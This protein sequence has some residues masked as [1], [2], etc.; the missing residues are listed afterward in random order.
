MAFKK[1]LVNLRQEKSYEIDSKIQYNKTFH[2]VFIFVKYYAS[3]CH[4]TLV[5]HLRVRLE[6]YP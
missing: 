5:K 3:V 2:S 6:A 1:E 4:S